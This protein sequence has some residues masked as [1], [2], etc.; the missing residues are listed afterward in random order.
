LHDVAA[1]DSYTDSSASGGLKHYHQLASRGITSVQ[2][3]CGLHTYPGG[4]YPTRQLGDRLSYIYGAYGANYPVWCTEWGYNNA[5]AMTEGQRPISEEAAGIYGPR[6]YL[7]FITKVR[8]NGAPRDLRLTYYELLDD[9]DAGAKDSHENNFGM[10][11]VSGD[12]PGAA[13]QPSSWRQ[14]PVAKKVGAFLNALKDPPGTR[15]YL[16]PKVICGVRTSATGAKLQW[17]VTA[18]KAQANAGTATVWLWRDKDIW[19]RDTGKPISVGSVS[20]DVT[21]QAGTRRFSIGAEVVP[22]TLR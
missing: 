21:D 10:F 16:P 2:D 8:P 4:S 3:Y 11:G 17:Q 9:Y 14:K 13:T 1:Q 7:Q 19:D 20:V 22:V 6:S 15:S 18:T 5:L 12:S